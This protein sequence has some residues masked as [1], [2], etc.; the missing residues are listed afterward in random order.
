MK[1]HTD[2]NIQSFYSFFDDKLAEIAQLKCAGIN[3]GLFQQILYV[4]YLDALSKVVFPRAG[5]RQRMT[6]LLLNFSEWKYC[7]RIS[8]PHLEKLLKISPEPS[9]EKLR[10]FV[11]DELEKWE[12]GAKIS[13][14][15]DPIKET[16]LKLW[17]RDE[18]NKNPLRNVNK[19][20]KVESLQHLNLFYSNRNRLIHELND[21]GRGGI[22]EIS[23]EEPYYSVYI[24][25]P[26]DFDE[27]IWVLEYPVAF[28]YKISRNCLNN[29]SSYL[30]R[31]QIDP[32]S[33]FS[34]GDYWIEEL[35][36]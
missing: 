31:N 5:N 8:L 11:S 12:S 4:T 30:S 18:E 17:P 14:D 26:H 10:L 21:S 9:F 33:F 29:I 27:S 32:L 1:N 36:T 3:K 25:G 2:L 6:N 16:I 22:P 35:N 34:Q 24:V 19:E 28:Y 13:L 20:F 7:E 15:Q 23:G